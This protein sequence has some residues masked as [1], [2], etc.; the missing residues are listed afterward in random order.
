M[1]RHAQAPTPSSARDRIAGPRAAI[2]QAFAVLPDIRT[3]GV[4]G[5]ER[6]YGH[7]VIIGR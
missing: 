6:T 4:M 1:G 7:P 3:V 5:D 2:W